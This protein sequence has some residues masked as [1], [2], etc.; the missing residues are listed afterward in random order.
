MVLPW[1]SAYAS[2]QHKIYSQDLARLMPRRTLRLA[3]LAR[4][5]IPLEPKGGARSA[6]KMLR[7]TG[8]LFHALRALSDLRLY[9]HVPSG[10]CLKSALVKP[11][12]V[13]NAQPRITASRSPIGLTILSRCYQATFYFSSEEAELALLSLLSPKRLTVSLTLTLSLLSEVLG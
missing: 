7:L 1:W 8:S 9:T 4:R 10:F 12:G 2:T 6:A 5:R 13:L 11:P 3:L